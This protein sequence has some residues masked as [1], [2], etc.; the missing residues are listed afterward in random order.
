VAAFAEIEKSLPGKLPV[1]ERYRLNSNGR[2]PE[3]SLGLLHSRRPELALDNHRQFNVVRHA[4]PAD[5]SIVNELRESGCLRLP[6]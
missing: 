6:V 1:V 4:H 5:V 2:P 3:K